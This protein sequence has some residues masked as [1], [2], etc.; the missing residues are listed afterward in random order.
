[1]T[2]VSDVLELVRAPAALTVLGDTAAGAQVAAGGF[3]RRGWMLP[4]A[5]VAIYSGGMALNDW[6]DR[7]LDA[8]ERPERPIP[9]G[10]ISPRRA[11]AV[12]A[13]LGAVGL[14]L[15]AAGGGRR[16]LAVAAPLV[17]SVALYDLVAKP[18][19]AGPLAMAACRGLDVLLGAGGSPRALP[20]AL[21][22]AVHTLGVTALSRGEVHGGSAADT[23][24][25]LVATGAAAAA[26]DSV[27]PGV[28]TA[29]ARLGGAAG[30]AVYLAAAL[31]G[32]LAVVDDPT[33]KRVRDA[34]RAGIGSVV[35]LQAA[36]VARGG[37]LAIAAG[38]MAVHATI[39][40][41]GRR[42]RKP[43]TGPARGD[44]T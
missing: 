1:M 4:L 13:G 22:I 19:T 20:A 40:Q 21:A 10:R 41:R 7:D 42:G 43:G 35:P 24:L 27:G 14:A 2:T 30:S 29:A 18:T 16:G 39:R 6:A 5:S 37:S 9:S 17:A 8:V 32:Q 31:P 25:S 33:P 38:L 11:L 3:D 15:A 23:A 44:V 12:A 34:T 36:I 26:V 28:Q